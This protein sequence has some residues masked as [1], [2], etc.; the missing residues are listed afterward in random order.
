MAKPLVMVENLK[1]YFATEEG[2]VKAV[3]DVSLTI[4]QGRTLGLV[5]ESG[6]GKSVTAMS[7]IRL[8]S[9]PGRIAGGRITMYPNASRLA[10]PATSAVG[11][12]QAPLGASHAVQVETTGEGRLLQAPPDTD[13]AQPLV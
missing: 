8:I 13:S 5:G 4:E 2:E 6:C 3:D 7:I 9:P 1:T 10:A 11:V 12:G